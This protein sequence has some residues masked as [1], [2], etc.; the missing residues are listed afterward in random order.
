MT[1]AKA[2]LKLTQKFISGLENYGL[3]YD[4]IIKSGWKYCGGNERSHLGYFKLCFGNI[5]LPEVEDKCVCGHE[6]RENCYITN[7]IDILVLG[8]CCIKKFIE[9]SMRTC[10]KCDEPHKNRKNNLC[11][12]CRV[13]DKT[14]LSVM[15][16]IIS[17]SKRTE[18]R[19]KQIEDNEVLKNKGYYG[20]VMEELARP[21]IEKEEN[22]RLHELQELLKKD[23][24]LCPD[25]RQYAVSKEKYWNGKLCI[26]C[27]K[28]KKPTYKKC[29]CGEEMES[30]K[31]F[32]ADCYRNNKPKTR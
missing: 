18:Q 21:L 13:T 6:I 28:K 1:S 24:N 11:N 3:T 27:L 10:S 30:W 9:K 25:C 4:D 2:S 20:R 32:C 29:S 19:K 15:N 22:E 7:N 12:N 26:P 23:Y 16:E 14:H 31:T 17:S 5:E 8:N